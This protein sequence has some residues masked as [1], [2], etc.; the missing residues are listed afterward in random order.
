MEVLI[1]DLMFTGVYLP[2]GVVYRD[3]VLRSC[4]NDTHW[5]IFFFWDHRALFFTCCFNVLTTSCCDC[6]FLTGW[7]CWLKS[8][9]RLKKYCKHSSSAAFTPRGH[10]GENG[11]ASCCCH[12]PR[13]SS[14]LNDFG[15][16]Q[17]CSDAQWLKNPFSP[18]TI[19]IH[20]DHKVTFCTRFWVIWG[21]KKSCVT[22]FMPFMCANRK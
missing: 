7:R 6:L 4:S 12:T 13:S 1:L 9:N 16:K 11:K 20:K 17:N 2:H 18:Y 14:G 21:F 5:S 8:Y 10:N 3:T 19:T 15:H 22:F